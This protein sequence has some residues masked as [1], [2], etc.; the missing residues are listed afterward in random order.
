MGHIYW[1]ASY[2]KSG[3]TWMRILLTNYLRNATEPANINDLDGG[4]IASARGTFDEYV[5]IEASDL[6]QSEIERYRPYVYEH[7][8]S[9]HARI[10]AKRPNLPPPFL[11]VHDAYTY[12]SEGKPLLSK[13]ATAGAV[14]IVRNPLDVA[15]SFAHHNNSSPELTVKHMAD[16]T[17]CFVDNPGKLHNQLRQKLLTWSGHVQSFL[18]EPD[19]RVLVVRY[20]DMLADTKKELSRV[21]AFAGLSQ[22]DERMERAVRFS[23]FE[24]LKGQENQHGFKEKMPKAKSFFR[25]GTAGSWQDVLTADL[26]DQ[27]AASHREVMQ[28]FGYL[29]E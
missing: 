17:F 20:E 8:S 12:T 11:K 4:P 2:P 21:L 10:L 25:S 9:E 18:N 16:E 3:N 24:T 19:V 23:S 29:P 1:L 15:V 26:Q 27:L 22:D 7:L 13:A 28:Q 6:S 14:Y 5:G